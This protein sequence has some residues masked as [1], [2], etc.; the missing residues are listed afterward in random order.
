MH[1][2]PY[3]DRFWARVDAS[4]DCWEWTG[5]TVKGYGAVRIKR[6]LWYAHRFAYELLVGP[7]PQGLE[8]DHLCRNL[9]CVNPDH[10]EPVTH[11]EN[12]RRGSQRGG[13]VLAALNR[14]KTHC[15]RGHPYD[16]ASTAVYRGQRHCRL[17]LRARARAYQE[18]KSA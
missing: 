4:G 8:L 1:D 11:A 15:P 17:C 5:A 7:I 14:S 2:A 16:E 10:L 18:R 12:M 13:R 9:P 6:R 3:A